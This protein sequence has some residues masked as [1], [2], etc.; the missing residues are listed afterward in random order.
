MTQKK[1]KFRNPALFL[2]GGYLSYVIIGWILL[3]FPFMQEQDVNALDNLF[4][5]TSAVS[6]TGLITV[7]TGSAT[8]SGGN[9]Y[10]WALFKLAV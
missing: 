7:D 9:W 5:A 6:T 3:S 10:C 8:P 1:E 4:M 2:V